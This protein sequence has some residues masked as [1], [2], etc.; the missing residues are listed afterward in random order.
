MFSGGRGLLQRAAQEQ[1]G[2]LALAS[3]TAG[4]HAAITNADT[5][6]DAFT[7]AP[8]Y[9]SHAGLRRVAREEPLQLVHRLPPQQLLRLG[10]R[11][12]TV[13]HVGHHEERL[14]PAAR[15][16]EATLRSAETKTLRSDSLRSDSI[17]LSEA[18][19]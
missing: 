7:H 5:R 3:C 2:L 14:E 18:A 15:P 1:K 4:T 6:I 19:D 12:D 13:R 16:H 11:V 10:V 17:R 9:V 8:I